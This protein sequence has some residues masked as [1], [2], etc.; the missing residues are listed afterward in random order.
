MFNKLLRIVLILL[1]AVCIF[2]PADKVLGL[3]V[4]LFVLAWIL[5]IVDVKA[6]HKIVC[7]PKGMILYLMLFLLIPLISIV[8]YFFTGIDFVNYDGFQ[9]FKSY[10]FITIALIFYVSKIDLV[11]P[12]V[13]VI[14]A[15]SIVSIMIL[16]ISYVNVS[17]F[18]YLQAE[19]GTR[20]GIFSTGVRDY[21]GFVLPEVYFHTAQ[22]IVFPIAYFT[23]KV[24]YLEGV[25][26]TL[27]VLLLVI[28]IVAMFFG[29]TRNNIIVS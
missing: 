25:S 10:L 8:Y 7:V 1:I 2:D 27:C 21:G 5:L 18:D 28:N 16:I 6:N 14:S 12:A 4:P 23:M 11:K 17:L 9:Y 13:A 26:R 15:L 19:I 20:Y 22:L 29:A 24:F 3:K